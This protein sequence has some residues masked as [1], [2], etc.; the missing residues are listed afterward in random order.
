MSKWTDC[1]KAEAAEEIYEKV[2]PMNQNTVTREECEAFLEEEWGSDDVQRLA[3]AH[4]ELL[5]LLEC[6]DGMSEREK[7]IRSLPGSDPGGDE[8]VSYLLGVI[9]VIRGDRKRLRDAN[10]LL[11]S[12]K[13]QQEE[14]LRLTVADLIFRKK[15]RD[16][17]ESQLAE[18]KAAIGTILIERETAKE[19]LAEAWKAIDEAGKLSTGWKHGNEGIHLLKIQSILS[20]HGEAIDATGALR[21]KPEADTKP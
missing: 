3:R 14:T 8:T 10:A 19:Q 20:G 21:A 6:R 9:D 17:L 15:E 7:F 1:A 18:A 13:L 4:L 11:E 5:T 2:P 12:Q 16:A